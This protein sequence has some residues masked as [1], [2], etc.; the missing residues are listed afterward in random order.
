MTFPNQ[1]IFVNITFFPGVQC[2]R[3]VLLQLLDS[4]LR[5][6]VEKQ[7]KNLEKPGIKKCSLLH[8]AWMDKSLILKS[9]HQC[10]LG[11]NVDT[12]LYFTLLTIIFLS[13][14]QWVPEVKQIKDN[15]EQRW[16]VLF[17]AIYN[18]WY[19]VPNDIQKW[20]SSELMQ[21]ALT[22]I[23]PLCK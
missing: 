5:T 7:N 2:S 17:V 20:K 16:T 4:D 13:D 11:W 10:K 8:S 9:M 18:L 23:G 15:F 19:I 12:K 6:L 1:K 21:S 3:D 14:S 22:T